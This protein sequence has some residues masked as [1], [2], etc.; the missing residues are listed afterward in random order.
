[1][2]DCMYYMCI[3]ICTYRVLMEDFLDTKEEAQRIKLEM[4]ASSTSRT[5][6][7]DY[8]IMDKSADY[9]HAHHSFS[10]PEVTSSDCVL[11]PTN[12]QKPQ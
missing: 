10:E 8:L 3:Y 2:A 4:N 6:T 7:T 12:S 5:A 9:V 11:C 1:M